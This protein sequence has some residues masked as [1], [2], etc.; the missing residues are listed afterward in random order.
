MT[1]YDASAIRGAHR[2]H[3]IKPDWPAVTHVHAFVTTRGDATGYGFNLANHVGDDLVCV[4]ARRQALNT[5]FNFSCAPQWLQQVHGTTVVDAQP[6]GIEQQGDA[7][8]T[9]Q[10][11]LP[12]MILTADCLPVL[13]CDDNGQEI[14]AAHA[15]WRGLAQGVLEAAVARMQAAPE[16]IY[17]WL[18]PAIGR[19][20]FEVG[21]DVYHA[22]VE[23]HPADAMAFA[24]QHKTGKWLADLQ[25][26]AR[27]R[28]QRCGVH[29]I[30][31]GGL[32][33]Y[34]DARFYSYRREGVTG[35]LLSCVWID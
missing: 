28:L 5:A 30:H 32:C 9:Q 15:G 27:Y 21:D 1:S 17:A 26:L 8:Y 18:G 10:S 19:R 22:F 2:Q 14:A 20:V 16:R 13:L 4:G 24:R 31:G 33:T 11:G 35:R 6:D 34:T 12:L 23:Q 3:W 29:Q 25:Q 7:A